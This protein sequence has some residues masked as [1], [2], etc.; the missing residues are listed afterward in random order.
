MIV[1]VLVFKEVGWTQSP[2]P[3]EMVVED[4]FI[5]VVFWWLWWW[6]VVVVVGVLKLGFDGQTSIT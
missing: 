4:S 1:V 3:Q 5:I 6:L 2:R